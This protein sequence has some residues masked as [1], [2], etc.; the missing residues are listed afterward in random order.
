MAEALTLAKEQARSKGVRRRAL[1][2]A[3]ILVVVVAACI[4]GP[5]ISP[6]QADA[7]GVGLP[8]APPSWAHWFG[9]DDLGRDLLSRVLA[10]GQISLIVGSG[11][12]LISLVVGIAW[13]I[14]AAGRRGW[15][16][17]LLMR[18]CDAIMAIPQL[19]F[20]L[21]CVAA[22]RPSVISLTIVIGLLMSPTTARMVRS[23]A[24]SELAD[25]YVVA[26]TA[27]GLTRR[28]LL[29]SEVLP[30]ILPPMVVQATTNMA[31]A[32][33]LEA[34]LSF[35]GLGIQPPEA[36]W[37]TLLLQGYAKM[38]NSVWFLMFPALIIVVT[39]ASLVLL[40]DRLGTAFDGKK[41]LR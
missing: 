25:D 15:I 4:L 17:T 2:P 5:S 21:V 26:A 1:I 31:D 34:T 9:T 7:L 32:I 8:F 16:D 6:Y 39:L 18:L 33:M 19:L 38:Y 30:N 36:S 14:A 3:I 27:S 22:F 24:V 35:V 29:V 13:G 10:G 28:R 12:T 20:A 11:A 41:I 40:S 23:T 37:G